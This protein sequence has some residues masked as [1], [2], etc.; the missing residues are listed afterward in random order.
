MNDDLTKLYDPIKIPINTEIE[1][2]YEDDDWNVIN[3]KKYFE[4]Q[5]NDDI[6]YVLATDLF[7]PSKNYELTEEDK[8]REGDNYNIIFTEAKIKLYNGPSEVFNYKE[9]SVEIG[10]EVAP[11]AI[12]DRDRWVYIDYKGNK[13]WINITNLEV[14]DED[15]RI[16]LLSDDEFLTLDGE[17]IAI[18]KYTIID[19]VY[20]NFKRQFGLGKYNNKIIKLYASL[21]GIPYD[22]DGE[23]KS[24]LKKEFNFDN[25]V[26]Y[27][28]FSDSKDNVF[29]FDVD[30]KLYKDASI[31]SEVLTV[32]PKNTKLSSNCVEGDLYGMDEYDSVYLV[33]YDNQK[34]YIFSEGQVSNIEIPIEPENPNE[35][36]INPGTTEIK[37]K[38]GT[39]NLLI[40]IILGFALT[41]IS[42]AVIVLCI[43]N[44]KKKK[45]SKE[46]V[47][48][49]ELSKNAELK[50]DNIEADNE[51]EQ[52]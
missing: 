43:K 8:L 29:S 51:N 9:I 25:N 27:C 1:A 20:F 7:D 15:T 23:E 22:L 34:G 10:K 47:K 35:I 26:Q 2:M 30:K 24:Q 13:G 45:T 3:G 21:D 11:T 42:I 14:R 41:L 18:P 33:E 36:I 17:K 49:E 38:N 44:S 50:E 4:V 6:C 39:S 12:Y 5:Y 19:E 28:Y 32:I 52:E 37:E 40:Y 31:D 48:V 16:M 46:E